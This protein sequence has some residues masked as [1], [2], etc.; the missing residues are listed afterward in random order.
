[1][2]I[3]KQYFSTLH[4]LNGQYKG[5]GG[6]EKTRLFQGSKSALVVLNEKQDMLH[7]KV[8]PV[9]CCWVQNKFSD[10]IGFWDQGLKMVLPRCDYKTEIAFMNMVIKSHIC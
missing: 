2:C 1:M 10:Q 3:V 6:A 5:L 8:N 7:T 9:K 4:Q